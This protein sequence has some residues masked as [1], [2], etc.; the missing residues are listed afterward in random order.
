MNHEVTSI[1]LPYS[2]VN[3]VISYITFTPDFQQDLLIP[4]DLNF[5]N[6]LIYINIIIRNF[7][8]NRMV[9]FDTLKL[10]CVLSVIIY[11]MYALKSEFRV[12]SRLES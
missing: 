1:L 12:V 2:N 7:R 4:T 11:Y 3:I 6:L 8:K 5:S 9:K 10:F